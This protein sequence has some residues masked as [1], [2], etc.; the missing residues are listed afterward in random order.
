MKSTYTVTATSV[1]TGMSIAR[2][3]R[4]RIVPVFN[5][6]NGTSVKVGKPIFGIPAS[7][8]VARR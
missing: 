4:G 8:R 3:G 5:K 7:V 1:I 2:D 6:K